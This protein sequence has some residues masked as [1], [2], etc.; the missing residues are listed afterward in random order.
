LALRD[1]IKQ[2]LTDSEELDQVVQ[3]VVKSALSDSDKITLD[4]ATHHQGGL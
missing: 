4:L 2:I 1:R 3:L